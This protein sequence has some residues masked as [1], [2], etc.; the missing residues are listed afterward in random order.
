METYPLRVRKFGPRMIILSIYG[1]HLTDL[2]GEIGIGSFITLLKC[3]GFSEQ[4]TR[5]AIARMHHHGMIEVRRIGKASYYSLSEDLKVHLRQ[6]GER[7]FVRKNYEWEGLWNIVVY[8]IPEGY[9]G[10]RDRIRQELIRIG[11]GPLAPATWISPYDF[12]K[13]VIDLTK[14][15]NASKYVKI[16]QTSNMNGDPK[17]IINRCWNIN[18][19]KR[20]YNSFIE[21]Y[22]PKMEH[23]QNLQKNGENVEPAEYFVE[24]CNLVNDYRNLM[25][26]DPD[27]PMSLLPKNWPRPRVV[28][29]FNNY[30]Q[31]LVEKTHE[32]VQSII[33][34]YGYER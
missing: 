9:R 23:Y 1:E 29:L 13:Q 22:A 2:E 6:S 16:F 25:L 28:Q 7:I 20:K 12:T 17:D 14:R 27:L 31:I 24:R 18:K 4:A 30:H 32:Y 21:D 10:L 33:E 15:H 11:Y 34:A 5:S 19:I 8:F 3:F 26:A